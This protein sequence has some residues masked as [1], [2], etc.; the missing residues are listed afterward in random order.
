MS[1]AKQA[2]VEGAQVKVGFLLLTVVERVL[3]PGDG[4][5]D[6]WRL[7]SAK[8][9]SYLFTPYNGLEKE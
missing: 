2:W 6:M 1:K 3:T 8:G 9:A 7:Q 4:L 5:P